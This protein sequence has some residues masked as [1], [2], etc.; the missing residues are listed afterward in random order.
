MRTRTTAIVLTAALAFTIIGVPGQASA[1]DCRVR[2][3]LAPTASG[4]AL[5]ATG[6]AEKRSQKLGARQ[7]L[8]V[9]A[10]AAVAA[11]FVN[12]ANGVSLAGTITMALPLGA[13]VAVGTLDLSNANVTPLP[14]GVDPVCAI[15]AIVVTDS[16]SFDPILIGS[17]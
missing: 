2:I 4:S 5:A 12:G 8:T 9:E 14:A 6:K 15:S 11:V 7:T 3:G 1:A 17:F 13:V 16:V 10:D